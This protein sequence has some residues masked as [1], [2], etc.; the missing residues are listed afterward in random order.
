MS[1]SP[2]QILIIVII[3]LLLFGPKR[4]P[5]LGQALGKAIRD[6]KN[7]LEGKNSKN[8]NSLSAKS[9]ALDPKQTSSPTKEQI[10]NK[11]NKS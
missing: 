3:L 10:K 1:I 6:F 8:S 5:G 11:E 7:S 9:E 2:W 4:L